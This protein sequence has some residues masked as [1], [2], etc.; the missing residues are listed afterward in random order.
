MC[1]IGE[2][3]KAGRYSRVYTAPFFALDLDKYYG[4]RQYC[5]GVVDELTN[6]GKYRGFSSKKGKN[7]PIINIVSGGWG[8]GCPN[9]F[10]R[11]CS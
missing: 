1:R 2:R 11:D 5:F 3:R 8:E 6:V 9:F 4:I 10:V 7:H